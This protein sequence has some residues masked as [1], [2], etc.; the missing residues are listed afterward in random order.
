MRKR[1]GGYFAIEGVLVATLAVLGFIEDR[2]LMPKRVAI[3]F[4]W[5]GT[6]GGYA[7]PLVAYSL[8]PCLLAAWFALYHAWLGRWHSFY[9]ELLLATGTLLLLVAGVEVLLAAIGILIPGGIIQAGVL[10]LAVASGAALAAR[11]DK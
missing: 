5:D 11:G 2:S 7:S 10:A 9:L 3:H 6:P 8:G 1:A 4:G